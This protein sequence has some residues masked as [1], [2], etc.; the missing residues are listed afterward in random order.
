MTLS[1]VLNVKSYLN[2]V[3]IKEFKFCL[4]IINE[5]LIIRK[6]ILQKKNYSFSTNSNIYRSFCGIVQNISSLKKLS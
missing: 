3:L 6:I 2:Q 1:G 4:G 5:L